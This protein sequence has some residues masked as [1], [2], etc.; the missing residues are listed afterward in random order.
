MPGPHVQIL[1]GA[2]FL[3]D[4][5][6]EATWA[7]NPR[8]AGQEPPEAA[9]AADKTFVVSP[10]KTSVASRAKTSVAAVG[11]TPDISMK[12]TTPCGERCL[13]QPP[14]GAEDEIEMSGVFSAAAADVLA[15]HATDVL[16]LIHISEPTRPY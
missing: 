5:P 12:S 16:S 2:I 7:G 15:L 11:K 4:F 6:P 3:E 10:E 13:R 9:L 8:F 1:R 14:Q